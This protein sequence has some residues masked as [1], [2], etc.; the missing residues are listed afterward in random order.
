MIH[1]IYPHV[2]ETLMWHS[3]DSR[4]IFKEDKW[5]FTIQCSITGTAAASKR[6]RWLG[7]QLSN[8]AWNMRSTVLGNLSD[9]IFLKEND[10]K[11]MKQKCT[12][13]D[14]IVF[15]TCTMLQNKPKCPKSPPSMQLSISNVYVGLHHTQ[16]YSV[17]AYMSFCTFNKYA[18]LCTEL[19]ITR[20]NKNSI[21]SKAIYI[22]ITIWIKI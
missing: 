22:W 1:D 5:K 14:C 11:F 17:W 13:L 3:C 12:A 20:K 4:N 18:E 15:V 19:S 2:Y 8:V 6:A 7:M 16:T 21:S 9:N 10:D